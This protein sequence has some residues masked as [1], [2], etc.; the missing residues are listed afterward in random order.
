MLQETLL[1]H[2]GSSWDLLSFFQPCVVLPF[3]LVQLP[4]TS[5]IHSGMSDYITKETAKFSHTAQN[6]HLQNTITLPHKIILIF[7]LFTTQS[8]I[9]SF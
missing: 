3:G 1:E 4:S 2:R 8:E 6:L 5:T 9:Y 7:L